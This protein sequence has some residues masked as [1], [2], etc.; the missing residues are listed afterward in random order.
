MDLSRTP[1]RTN[2]EIKARIDDPEAALAVCRALEAVD[3]G[4]FTQVDTYF[5]LGRHRLKLREMLNGENYLIG[6]SRPDVAGARKSQFRMAPVKAARTVKSLLSRQWGVKAIV[7]KTR[8]VFIWMERVRIHIDHVQELGD[9]LEFEAM[10]D[11]PG[12][13]DDATAALDLARLSHDFALRDADLIGGS[14]ANLILQG[15]A[16]PSGT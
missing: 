2:L 12:G 1:Q 11:E 9:Y 15:A 7:S 10:L 3:E 4:E 14:Y 8:R 13:Y 16:T 6:Y 5:T